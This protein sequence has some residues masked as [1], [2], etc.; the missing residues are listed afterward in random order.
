MEPLRC[1]LF[2]LLKRHSRSLESFTIPSSKIHNCSSETHWCLG[3]FLFDLGF[4][5]IWIL[6]FYRAQKLE[7][8]R[9][10]EPGVRWSAVFLR[11]ARS[12]WARIHRARLPVFSYSLSSWR[13]KFVDKMNLFRAGDFSSMMPTFYGVMKNINTVNHVYYAWVTIPWSFFAASQ[14]GG[15]KGV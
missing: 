5:P 4:C 9:S 11:R 15:L 6:D 8:G 2:F 1:L 10:R 3:S 13:E 14:R 12:H 7:P